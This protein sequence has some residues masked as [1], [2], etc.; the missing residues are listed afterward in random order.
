MDAWMS[1]SV[2]AFDADSTYDVCTYIR[3]CASKTYRMGKYVYVRERV[4]SQWRIWLVIF[5]SRSEAILF[6]VHHCERLVLSAFLHSELSA[7]GT[8]EKVKFAV[9]VH[10]D[11]AVQA[12][13]R[14]AF[15]LMHP[16]C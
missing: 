11:E 2:V 15:R 10:I 9:Y 3:R 6:Q 14:V 13:Q 1:F 4:L 16:L 5:V 7:P 12:S 8:D